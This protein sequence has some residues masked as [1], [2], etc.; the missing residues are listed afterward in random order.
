LFAYVVFGHILHSLI[1]NYQDAVCLQQ[2]L[3]YVH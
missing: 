2:L 3:L 1:I